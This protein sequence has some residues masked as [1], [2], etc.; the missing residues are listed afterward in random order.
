MVDKIINKQDIVQFINQEKKKPSITDIQKVFK[1]FLKILNRSCYDIYI[2]LKNINNLNLIHIIKCGSDL[3]WHVFW[4]VYTYS[5][6]IKLT[7]FLSERCILLFTEFI[8]MS[9]NPILNNDL[10]FVPNTNDAMQFSI[11]KTIGP[12][13]IPIMK[14]LKIKETI[15]FY[16]SLTYDY[17]YLLQQIFDHIIIN[18]FISNKNNQF[19]EE[20]SFDLIDNE[21][22]KKNEDIFELFENIINAFNKSIL[23]IYSSNLN[24][25]N[26]LYIIIKDV[27]NY[28]CNLNQKISIIKIYL[29]IIS[30]NYNNLNQVNF[31]SLL[32]NF[33]KILFDNFD[34]LNNVLYD[35]ISSFKKKKTYK[36]LNSLL[37]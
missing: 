15:Y 27:F 16:K 34:D 3:I 12:L 7:M 36:K 5:F 29:D 14:S 26:I 13:K 28:N 1:F 22:I 19:S 21:L 24:K 8:I 20:N 31:E 11:K 17:K 37:L 33:K 25:K 10:S 32:I 35:N 9:R 6:N 23:I 4:V 30:N 2:K 18:Y